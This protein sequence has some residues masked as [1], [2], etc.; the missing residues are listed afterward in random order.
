MTL[1]SYQLYPLFFGF[2]FIAQFLITLFFESMMQTL[3]QTTQG[4]WLAQVMGG[5]TDLIIGFI[6]VMAYGL[7]VQNLRHSPKTLSQ[8]LGDTLTP[9]ASESLLAFSKIILGALLF[10][11]PGIIFYVYYVFLSYVVFYDP[12][13]STGNVSALQKSKQLVKPAFFSVFGYMVVLG[14]ISL[15]L[16]LAPNVL[17]LIAWWQELFF[18]ALSF[19]FTG[20]GFMIFYQ[21]YRRL[22][23]SQE[24]PS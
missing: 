18:F 15:C 23:R 8:F 13:Y 22:E 19:Y 10:I 1:Q 24:N 6:L 7:A 17:N 12:E 2:L 21:L 9:L 4:P 11:I 16:E 5:M 20:L 3:S 14:L